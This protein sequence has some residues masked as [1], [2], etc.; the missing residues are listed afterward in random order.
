M[1]EGGNRKWNDDEVKGNKYTMNI[2]LEKFGVY[3]S[4]LKTEY[5]A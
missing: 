4:S 1:S 3:L 2:E 5:V